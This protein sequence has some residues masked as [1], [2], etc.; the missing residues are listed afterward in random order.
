MG[1]PRRLAI[2]DTNLAA[3]LRRLARSGDDHWRAGRYARRKIL[4]SVGFR[5]C[6]LMK[7]PDAE[8][9]PKVGKTASRVIAIGNKLRSH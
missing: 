7:H 3:A 4:R 8:P 9:P 6:M 5:R 2:R 1:A